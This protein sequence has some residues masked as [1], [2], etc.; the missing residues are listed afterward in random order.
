MQTHQQLIE[1]NQL[2]QMKAEQQYVT[3]ADEL[4]L[5]LGPEVIASL[6]NFSLVDIQLL[7]KLKD[8][9]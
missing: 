3:D 4:L 2:N 7:Y 8:K 5:K 1:I 6:L 9:I